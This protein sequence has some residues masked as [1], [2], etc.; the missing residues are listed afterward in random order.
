MLF[1][2]TD[3]VVKV[4]DFSSASIHDKPDDAAAA[5]AATDAEELGV[6]VEKKLTSEVTETVTVTGTF[7]LL[8]LSLKCC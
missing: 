5:V 2:V 7:S 1:V 4:E 3:E 6:T 8:S